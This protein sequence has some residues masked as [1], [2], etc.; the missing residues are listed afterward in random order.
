LFNIPDLTAFSGLEAVEHK[1]ID[2]VKHLIREACD[3]NRNR[4]LV[5]I[6]DEMSDSICR[7]AD[8]VCVIYLVWLLHILHLF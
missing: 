4:K 6:M 5:V 2:D 7:V 1:C 8:M 3:P